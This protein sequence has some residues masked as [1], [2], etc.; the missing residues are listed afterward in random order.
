MIG[1]FAAWIHGAPV[2][3]MDVDI[4]Y[5]ATEGNASAL[6]GA[7]KELDACYRQR[8]DRKLTPT[9]AG[10]CSTEAAGH[11][12]LE[13][14]F[15]NLDV[16]RTVVGLGYRDLQSDAVSIEIAGSVSLFAPLGRIISLK[17]AANRPKDRAA[18]PTLRSALEDSDEEH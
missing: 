15:G 16:L 6:I 12:L 11:H 3:T 1:G 14:R 5:S 2:V 8:A 13:T 10:L 17:E 18:L 7:L 4:V 9:S